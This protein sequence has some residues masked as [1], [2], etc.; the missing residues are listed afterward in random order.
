MW[1]N[2]YFFFFWIAFIYI[3]FGPTVQLELLEQGFTWLLPPFGWK[4]GV[5]PLVLPLL[6]Q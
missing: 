4:Q 1:F 2:M 5:I 3:P 6:F